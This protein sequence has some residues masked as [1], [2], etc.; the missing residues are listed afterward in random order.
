MLVHLSIKNLAVIE[1]TEFSP[2]PGLNIFTGETGTGKS[3][4]IDAIL[5]A[6]GERASTDLLRTGAKEAEITAIFSLSE[7][8]PVK[9]FLSEHN[10]PSDGDELILRRVITSSGRSRAY[11]NDT[12]TT[13]RVLQ[14]LGLLLVEISSQHSHQRLMQPRFHLDFLDQFGNLFPLRKELTSLYQKYRQLLERM[15]SLGGDPLQRQRQKEF[16]EFQI[17]ELEEF[18]LSVEEEELFQRH[19]YLSNLEQIIEGSEETE[20][21]LYSGGNA[22]FDQLGT[23]RRK[24]EQW[25]EF[26]QLLSETVDILS[27]AESLIDEA[28]RNI[29][30]FSSQTEFDFRE[31]EELNQTIV[32]LNDLKRKHNATSIEEL[33]E[34]LE[35][36]RRELSHLQQVE[37]EAV[38]LE[39]QISELRELLSQK[40]RELSEKRRE[41]AEEL[42]RK[43]E[44]ELSSVGMKKAKFSIRWISSPEEE[45][46]PGP[47]GWDEIQFYLSP[48][49]GEELKPLHKIASGGELS[50]ILLA[51]NQIFSDKNPVPTIIFDEIDSGIGG[52]TALNVGDKIY[53]IARN[54]QVLC[55][56]HLPQIAALADHHFQIHKEVRGDRTVSSV[57]LLSDKDRSRELARM[58]DGRKESPQSISHAARLLKLAKKQK[59]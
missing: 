42:S 1:K 32:K 25:S 20:R 17:S 58:L 45:R 44:S 18:D 50:R 22:I 23:A 39:R 3:I 13:V 35:G 19:R 57:R 41:W 51:L 27:K 36:Y 30:Q 34:I 37:E 28:A 5:L 6:L 46:L 33:R 56:T 31:L 40:A 53:Q 16:L 9:E 49:P 2:G 43:V 24:L 52:E 15:E 8:S 47:T 10:F 38:S 59:R 7:D 55:V 54:R 48:N 11:V 26:S 21:M 12:P 4:L 29:R 14:Q